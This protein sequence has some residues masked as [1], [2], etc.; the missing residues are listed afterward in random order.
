MINIILRFYNNYFD[1]GLIG[2][3]YPDVLFIQLV[4]WPWTL[5]VITLLRQEYVLLRKSV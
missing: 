2:V 5:T 3:Y 1:F 4:L